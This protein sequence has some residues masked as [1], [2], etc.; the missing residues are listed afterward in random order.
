MVPGKRSACRSGCRFAAKRVRIFMI[1]EVL[2][3][4]TGVVVAIVLCLGV[5][6]WVAVTRNKK[7]A[8]DDRK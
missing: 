4:G 1:W 7:A 8:N 3:M 6:V 2:F 5:A